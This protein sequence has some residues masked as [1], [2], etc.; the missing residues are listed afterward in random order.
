MVYNLSIMNNNILSSYVSELKLNASEEYI[1]L[2]NSNILGEVIFSINT[3]SIKCIFNESDIAPK[4]FNKMYLVN[5]LLGNTIG[6]DIDELGIIDG[7]SQIAQY[8]A[9]YTYNKAISQM[10]GICNDIQCATDISYIPSI[11]QDQLF[12]NSILSRKASDGE[13]SYLVLDK[14]RIYMTPNMIPSSKSTPVD[15]KIY[16]TNGNDYI[17]ADFISHK[18]RHEVHTYMR[19]LLLS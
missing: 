6:V 7:Q 14:Y 19:F 8:N 3:S 9:Y 17:L 16:Y 5:A 2:Y 1:Y 15:M 11:N 13:G 12:Y 18:K 10:N 4:Y